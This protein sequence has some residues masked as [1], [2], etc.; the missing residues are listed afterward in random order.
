M[1]YKEVEHPSIVLPPRVRHEDYIRHP[2][3]AD[4]IVPEV[5]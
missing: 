5:Y 1:P 3:P 2:V 4:L